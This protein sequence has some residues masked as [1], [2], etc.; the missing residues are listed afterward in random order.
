M[1]N[2]AVAVG[3]AA[4]FCIYLKVVAYCIFALLPPNEENRK[5]IKY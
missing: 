4:V 1:L 2:L 5:S 3:A